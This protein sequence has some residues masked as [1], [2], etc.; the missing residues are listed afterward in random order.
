[1]VYL[2]YI[3]LD[4]LY[5]FKILP[6]LHAQKEIDLDHYISAFITINHKIETSFLV[7]FTNIL[8]M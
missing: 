6:F 2:D 3:L 1:M 5:K 7:K 8:S 4:F